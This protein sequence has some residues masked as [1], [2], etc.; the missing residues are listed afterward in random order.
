MGGQVWVLGV[1]MT[2]FGK[3]ESKDVAE[4]ALE[5]AR[6]AVADGGLEPRR[7]EAIYFANSLC[8]LLTGQEAVRGQVA[9]RDSPWRGVPV[10]NVENAC[11]SSSAALHVA[12]H[13]IRAGEYEHVLVVGAEKLT[14]PDKQTTFRALA[15]ASDCG[16]EGGC[17]APEARSVF[18]DYYAAV[19]RRHMER[20]GTTLEQMAM[21]GAK[22]SAHGALNPLAQ[23]RTARSVAEV[24][25]SR[26]V[27]DPLRLFMCSP[28]GDGAAAVVLGNRRPVGSRRAVCVLAS[29]LRSGTVD[30]ADRETIARTA[31]AA[32]ER[33][34]CGPDD[35]HLCEVHD[36]TAIA[37][38]VSYEALGLCAEGEGGP[39]VESGA[40][41]LRGRVP[42]NPSGG[43]IARGH[44]VGATGLA[45]CCEL[46]WQ[47]RGEA[48]ARQVEGARVALA[49]NH[50]GLVGDD[51]AACCVT[52][53][54]A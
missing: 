8:G 40:A 46:T 32:Y 49:E 11:A 2:P 25:Q 17:A 44:P 34:G 30:G 43:L 23:F 37:E 5:A 15:A 36:A 10:V 19:A 3:W 50:G 9:L 54:T 13:A 31:R 35:L 53:L 4:L 14:H 47:L 39:F 20:Y 26:L 27:V 42:V 33:A 1:G 16:R 7:I 41:S 51:V 28:I 18:M 29:A 22:N 12:A 21:V 45:Q 48:G 6:A 38:I 24:L 52:I